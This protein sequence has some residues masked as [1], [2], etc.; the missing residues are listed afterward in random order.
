[1]VGFFGGTIDFLAQQQ[2]Q[3]VCVDSELVGWL[4]CCSFAFAEEAVGGG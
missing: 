3:H 2:H 1:M 4:A